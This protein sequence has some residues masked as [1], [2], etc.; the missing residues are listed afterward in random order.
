MFLK[1]SFHKDSSVERSVIDPPASA[2]CGGGLK[3]KY[4]SIVDL[5][6]F[7]STI[8][9]IVKISE[10]I[11]QFHS[12]YTFVLFRARE[13]LALP[14]KKGSNSSWNAIR[15]EHVKRI[16]YTRHLRT[17]DLFFKRNIYN[18]WFLRKNYE[19]I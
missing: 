6:D 8:T 4:T 14:S 17:I 5:F 13:H 16:V 19:N 10:T 2:L 15:A 18:P 1:P 9:R 3:G 11:E 7:N 12:C